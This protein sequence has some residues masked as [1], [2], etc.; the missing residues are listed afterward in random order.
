MEPGRDAAR[1]FWKAQVLAKPRAEWQLEQWKGAFGWYLEWLRFAEAENRDVLSLPERVFG[2]VDR[3]GGRRGLA[4]RTRETYARWC[5]RFAK[6]VGDAKPMLDQGPARDFL[7]YLVVDEKQS[8]STQKQALNA[9]VFFYKEVC[10]KEVVDLQVKLKKTPKRIPVVIDFKEVL[11]IL[12]RMEGRWRLMASTQ[13]GGG[14]RLKELM[15]LRVKDVDLERRQITVRGGKG[16]QDRVTILPESLVEPLREHL[17]AVREVY[18]NDRAAES[19]GVEIP[20]ALAR[21]FSKAG[22]S[23]EWFWLFPAPD[24][25]RDPESGVLRRHH[26]HEECYTRALKKAVKEEGITKRVTSHVLRHAFATH[27]LE[28]GKDIRTVQELLGHADVSTTQI[29]THV[30]KGVGGTGVQSPL[31]ALF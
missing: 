10:G 29:Y 20:G 5:V 12:R 26:V 9:L 22:K 18:E 14:L 19:P 17:E 13:Y 30:A 3:A 7:T 16:D 24:I 25:S 6:W 2:A 8:F 15:R 27:L 23:W 31:D 1:A 11:A 21:K 4:R 28:G